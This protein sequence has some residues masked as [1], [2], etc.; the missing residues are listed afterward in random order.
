[1]ITPIQKD[2]RIGTLAG[3]GQKSADYIAA[4]LP[5]GFESFEINF[6][7]ELGQT[8]LR[9]LARQVKDVLAGSD[10]VVSSLG[11]YGNPLDPSSPK[12]K[13][14]LKGWKACIDA[15]PLFG[16]DLVCG[17]AGRVVNKPIPESMKA[18]RKIFGDLAKHAA[19]KGVRIAFE[20]C[21]MGGTWQSG[22]WNIAQYPAAWEMMFHEVP[23]KNLGL[24]WE[25]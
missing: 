21:D 1:M 15:A 7:Q 13:E 24:E 16:C 5:H 11:M 3:K 17:F 19:D 10:A 18:F 25:P 22:D 23:A 9:K 8:D 20:N 14:T 6:W 2:I 12:H 4:L